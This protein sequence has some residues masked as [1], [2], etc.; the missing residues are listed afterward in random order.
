M[1]N[2]TGL[3]RRRCQSIRENKDIPGS[4]VVG[5]GRIQAWE[6]VPQWA[7]SRKETTASTAAG[8]ELELPSA[9]AEVPETAEPSVAAAIGG[10][11]DAAVGAAAAAE[12][13][14]AETSAAVEGGADLA[15]GLGASPGQLVVHQ[16]PVG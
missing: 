13:E 7:A 3:D 1:G 15:G 11:T 5:Q 8:L 4:L 9:E 12:A 16:Q 2:N 10:Q 6:G 14:A